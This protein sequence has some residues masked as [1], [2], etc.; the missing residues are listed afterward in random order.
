MQIFKTQ[1]DSEPVVTD[2]TEVIEAGCWIQLF[3]PR[4]EDV[5]IFFTMK[6]ASPFSAL[7]RLWRQESC[8][9]D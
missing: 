3:N 6:I 4:E 8:G 9:L 1:K 7:V 2:K 5:L